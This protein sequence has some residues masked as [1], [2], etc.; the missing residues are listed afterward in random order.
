MANASTWVRAT[1]IGHFLGTGIGVAGILGIVEDHMAQFALDGDVVFVRVFGHFRQAFDIFF[2]GR[3]AAVVH[4]G[5]EAAFNG[6]AH[7]GFSK[8]MI[9]VQ[10]DGNLGA[11]RDA[12]D[13]AHDQ[14][15]IAAVEKSLGGTDDDRRLEFFRCIHYAQRHLDAEGVKHTHAIMAHARVLKDFPH[16]YQHCLLPLSYRCITE[17]RCVAAFNSAA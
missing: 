3:L 15:H 11:P 6:L 8:S 16:C 9:Q 1:K 12:A 17:L 4:D 5:S 7:Q 14:F 10:G 13:H 2:I